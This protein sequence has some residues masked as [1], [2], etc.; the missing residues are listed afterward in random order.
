MFGSSVRAVIPNDY[1]SLH[2]VVTR[3]E[4]LSQESELGRA[5]ESFAGKL[6]GLAVSQVKK[7]KTFW[8]I[9]PV[10]SHS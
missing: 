1:F 9:K 6:A 3:G 10:F 7:T 2:R 4:P 5:I 8:G